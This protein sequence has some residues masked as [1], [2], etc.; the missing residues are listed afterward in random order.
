MRLRVKVVAATRQCPA[1]S[2]ASTLIASMHPGA[3]LLKF[4]TNEDRQAVLRGRKGLT[5]TKL[6]LDENLTP[7]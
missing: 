1:T 3:V 7:T 4:T 6:G 5:W 2:W